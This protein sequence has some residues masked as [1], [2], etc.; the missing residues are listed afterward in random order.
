M[1]RAHPP[2][3]A[4]L[5][6][7]VALATQGCG[8]TFDPYNQL[9]GFRLLAVRAEPPTVAPGATA[10]IDA[11]V[12]EPDGPGTTYAWSWCPVR[13]GADGAYECAMSEADFKAE[14][15][16]VGVPVDSLTFDLGTNETAT[17][18]YPLDPT[19]LALICATAMG[20]PGAGAAGLL[21]CDQ[22]FPVSVG[23]TVRYGDKE[24]SGFKTL[25]LALD[26]AAPANANPVLTDLSVAEAKGTRADAAVLP[27]GEP[28]YTMVLGEKYELFAEVPE[29]AAETFFGT[30]TTG[31][32]PTE[33]REVLF[34]TWF[35]DGGS[36]AH[37]RTTFF[38][39]TAGFD[40]LV[41][42]TW[43]LP[44]PE[45]LGRDR[46]RL[47]LVLRDNRGGVAWLRRDVLVGR[48]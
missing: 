20:P 40:R 33:Q 6:V 36:T 29:A 21:H 7:G 23:L 2:A 30:T 45:E 26:A 31:I 37:Q 24:I 17:F 34:I 27:A 41:H 28:T 15:E 11:L 46:A 44:Q 10:T 18:A 48:P 9:E 47:V 42:N 43:T 12:Y 19:I 35:V 3:F 1:K 16:A 22:G 25:R 32:A 4:A 5:A 13:T 39:G 14:L 38:E 8:S